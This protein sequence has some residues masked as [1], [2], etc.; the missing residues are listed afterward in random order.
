MKGKKWIR[1]N[2]REL[3]RVRENERGGEGMKKADWERV[4]Q[5]GKKKWIES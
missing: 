1:E 2:K 4:E 3:L 5:N